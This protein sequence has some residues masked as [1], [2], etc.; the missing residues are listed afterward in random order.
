METQRHGDTENGRNRDREKQRQ[1]ALRDKE[2]H[3]RETQMQEDTETV[4]FRDRGTHRKGDTEIERNIDRVSQ[5]QKAIKSILVCTQEFYSFIHKI[6][7][8]LGAKDN[9]ET[10]PLRPDRVEAKKRPFMPEI[11]LGL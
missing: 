4:K 9:R 7:S 11:G 2:Q 1:G 3:D 6:S 5:R 8:L 10:I